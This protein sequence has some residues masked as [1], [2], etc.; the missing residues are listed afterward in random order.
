[1]CGEIPTC[2]RALIQNYDIRWEWYPNRGEIISVGVFAKE[3]TDPIER[4]Y[5]GSSGTRIISYV[6]A[7]GASNRGIEVELRKQLGAVSGLLRNVALFTNAT[8]MKSTIAIDPDAGSITNASRRMVGQAPYVVNAGLTWTHPSAD[9]SATVLFNR[10]G[11]RITEAGELPLPDVIE[12]ARSVL[13]VSLRFPIA[14]ALDGRVDARNLLDA[15][16]LT[17]QGDVTR[18]RYRAGRVFAV[19]FSW[20]P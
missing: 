19:G 16:Y 10:V 15:P 1:M 9:A 14:G 2:K 3:F 12:Q 7:R 6:N 5:L 8:V 20:K 13:D 11:S 4:I 17:T 18:E